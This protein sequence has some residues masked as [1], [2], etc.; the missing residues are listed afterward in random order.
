[1]S[2]PRLTYPSYPAIHFNTSQ[3]SARLSYSGSHEPTSSASTTY[4]PAYPHRPSSA[5]ALLGL[6]TTSSAMSGYEPTGYTSVHDTPTGT[7]QD[8]ASPGQHNGSS[9]ASGATYR[10]EAGNE[11]SL[12][13]VDSGAGASHVLQTCPDDDRPRYE[14]QPQAALPLSP[15][16]Q[17]G[18]NHNPHGSYYYSA[19][20]DRFYQQQMLRNDSLASASSESV[21]AHSHAMQ[22][23]DSGF[24][25]HTPH[26]GVQSAPASPHRDAGLAAGDSGYVSERGGYFTHGHPT[27]W[28]GAGAPYPGAPSGL[29]YPRPRTPQGSQPILAAH[30]PARATETGREVAQQHEVSTI[31]SASRPAPG[32]PRLPGLL[33]SLTS[34]Y[35]RTTRS[36]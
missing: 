6:S 8:G 23:Q 22:P 32:T 13:A 7:P 14:P 20:R 33:D 4:I 16:L 35:A 3:G 19:D 9:Q 31:V 27:V 26:H 30:T 28:P 34:P 25:Q 11:F 1:M 21:S 29:H 12:P 2:Q 17:D 5:Q 18:R 15:A 36:T 10:D 24:G